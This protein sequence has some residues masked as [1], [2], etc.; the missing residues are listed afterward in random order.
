MFGYHAFDY[1]SR[2]L[3]GSTL[4]SGLHSATIAPHTIRSVSPSWT[5]NQLWREYL[6][7]RCIAEPSSV[8]VKAAGEGTPYFLLWLVKRKGKRNSFEGGQIP[9]PDYHG[10]PSKWIQQKKADEAR[11]RACYSSTMDESKRVGVP[12]RQRL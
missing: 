9:V 8:E 7:D 2:G 3:R 12:A 5:G 10:C 11:P 4:K 1:V 6:G